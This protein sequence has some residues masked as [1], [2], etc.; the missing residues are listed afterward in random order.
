MLS[1]TLIRKQN[2]SKSVAITLHITEAVDVRI[3]LELITEMSAV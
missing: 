2:L 1:W 3:D